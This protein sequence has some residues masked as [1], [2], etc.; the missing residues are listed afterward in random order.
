M[1]TRDPKPMFSATYTNAEKRAFFWQIALGVC[2]AYARDV[3]FCGSICLPVSAWSNSAREKGGVG[4]VSK[5]RARETEHRGVDQ[6]RYGP[7][8]MRTM[9]GRSCGNAGVGSVLPS[10][11]SGERVARCY[12]VSFSATRKPKDGGNGN[13]A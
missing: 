6:L 10:E 2:L 11:H 9:Q 12:V 1:S 5:V 8:A 4:Y 13:A 7:S 3:V